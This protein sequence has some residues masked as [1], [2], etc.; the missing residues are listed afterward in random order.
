M[1]LVA[2]GLKPWSKTNHTPNENDLVDAQ[3]I[4]KLINKTS[5]NDSDERKKKQKL[6]ESSSFGKK[7]V[8]KVFT[9]N[10]PKNKDAIMG[11]DDIMSLRSLRNSQL[12][13]ENKVSTAPNFP[14]QPSPGTATAILL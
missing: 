14:E 1:T 13:I 11:T 3:E 2:G 7:I 6:K 5:D 10:L 8:S 4:V 12:S 9:S